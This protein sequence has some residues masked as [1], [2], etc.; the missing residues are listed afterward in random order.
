[1]LLQLE[2]I[3]LEFLQRACA[4]ENGATETPYWFDFDSFDAYN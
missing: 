2:K 4:A 1:M 3:E